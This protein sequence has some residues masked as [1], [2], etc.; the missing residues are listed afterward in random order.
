MSSAQI[1]NLNERP[2]PVFKKHLANPAEWKRTQA[3]CA[4]PREGD[5]V[6][7]SIDPVATVAHL[8]NEARIAAGKLRT[9]KYV[10]LI[11]A[12]GLP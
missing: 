10:A 6:I 2:E 11:Y 5:F 4:M 3:T 12:V 1:D 7:L 8:D 9:R